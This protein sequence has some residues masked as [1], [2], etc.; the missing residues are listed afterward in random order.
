LKDWFGCEATDAGPKQLTGA[1]QKDSPND[2]G[3]WWTVQRGAGPIV[4]TAIHD[5]H[6]LRPEV[7]GIIQLSE[8]ERLREEDPFTGQA[9]FDVPTHVIAHRSRFEFDLNRG[10]DEAIYLTSEQSWGLDVWREPPLPDSV[11]R[12][13][14]I[15]AAY[16]AMLGQLLDGVAGQHERFVLI[17]VHSYNHRREGPDGPWTAQDQAPDINIGTFSMPREQWAFLLDPLMEAMGTFDFNGRRLDVRENIAFQ[18]KGEQTRFVHQHYPGRGC[19]IAVEFKKFF[20]DEWTGVPD[21]EELS[22]MRRFVSFT[23]ATAERL[24]Q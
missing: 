13:L 23:A 6:D 3:R 14:A 19:A 16:Y 21:S 4:A 1:M 22:A 18:G 12:S 20:M 9:I 5:G 17:D 24:L 8:A 10:R 15:H 7:A 2:S 11:E